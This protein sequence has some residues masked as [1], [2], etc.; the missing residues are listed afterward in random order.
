MVLY[1]LSEYLLL[2]VQHDKIWRATPTPAFTKLTK[3]GC[4]KYFWIST[5]YKFLELDSADIHN[6]DSTVFVSIILFFVKCL[7]LS[8]HYFLIFSFLNQLQWLRLCVW[9][10]S[11]QSVRYTTHL[12]RCF[13]SSK[14]LKSLHFSKMNIF[15]WKYR[16]LLNDTSICLF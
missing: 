10:N 16:S 3:H 6:Q 2:F 4:I 9:R 15:V 12:R 14:Q 11:Y 1:N 5:I 13:R 7:I 8:L